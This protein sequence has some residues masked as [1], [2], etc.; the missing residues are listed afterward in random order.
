MYEGFYG[1]ERHPFRLV[2]DPS[3]LFASSGV[4]EALG[5]L[6]YAVKTGKGIA[7]MTGEV[8]TGKTT[9]VNRFLDRAGPELRTAYIFNPTLT[10]P[11]LL[12]TLAEELGVST[13]ATSKLELTRAL[14][15]E[16]LRNHQAGRR[17]IVFVD[18]A[19]VL[20][21]EALEELRL[22]SNL[23]TWH[24][25]LLHIVLVGQ[26]ELLDHLDAYQ[27]RPLRQRVELYVQIEPMREVETRQY[28]EHRLRVAN[29]V[30]PVAFTD[31]ACELVH[32]LAGG[33]PRD[34]NKVC[35]AALLVA[36]VDE[37]STI[38]SK[39]VREAVQT[40]DAQQIGLHLGG[41]N[42]G[43]LWPRAWAG[44][45]GVAALVALLVAYDTAAPPSRSASG[46]QAVAV[47]AAAGSATDDLEQPESEASLVHLAS[48]EHRQ[49]AEGFV[50]QIAAP[51]DRVVYLQSVDANGRRWHR[52]LL[53][54]FRDLGAAQAWAQKM[55]ERGTYA[56]AQP[57]RVSREGLE[58]WGT[59]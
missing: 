1:F 14:Y 51:A 9:L 22:V 42:A 45:A 54:D 34:I 40:I 38:T 8:G 49:Q 33:I 20:A 10:G 47:R 56:Y 55:R 17:T 26:P 30:R 39:H 44:A 27:M 16:L 46:V 11:Q 57:V 15:A 24:E 18:E 29:P 53:G 59:R 2:A 43:R 36:Y 5:R 25:K 12:R 6:E 7:V 4:R 3:M 19:Q 58:A 21:P 37:A 48:F 50:R 31:G 35:D 23:E 41:T 28:I 32:R 13:D 52:V